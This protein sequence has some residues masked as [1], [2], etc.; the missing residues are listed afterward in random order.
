MMKAELQETI[1]AMDSGVSIPFG[2]ES[3]LRKDKGFPRKMPDG[4]HFH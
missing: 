2:Q 3:V 1:A 4:G